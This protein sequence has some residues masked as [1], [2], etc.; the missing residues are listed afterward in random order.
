MFKVSLNS[1]ATGPSFNHFITA[2]SWCCN[3]KFF[4]YPFDIVPPQL[5]FIVEFKAYC[6]ALD[7]SKIMTTFKFY[8]LNRENIYTSML[9]I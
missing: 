8:F 9:I 6:F 1:Y 5:S 4:W 2:Q 7:F 3:N